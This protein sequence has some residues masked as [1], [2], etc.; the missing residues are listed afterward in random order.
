MSEGDRSGWSTSW[1]YQREQIW[2]HLEGAAFDHEAC[3]L[4]LGDSGGGSV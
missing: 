2:V 1:R 3:Y 4:V